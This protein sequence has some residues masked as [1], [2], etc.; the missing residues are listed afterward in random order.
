[1]GLY[2]VLH[3]GNVLLHFDLCPKHHVLHLPQIVSVLIK[4]AFEGQ[5]DLN[6]R[7]EVGLGLFNLSFNFFDRLCVIGLYCLRFLLLFIHTEQ[8]FEG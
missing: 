4:L 1:M 2:Q 8:T 5:G 3:I 6:L 7:L